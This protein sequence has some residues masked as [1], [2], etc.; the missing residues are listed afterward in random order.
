MLHTFTPAQQEEIVNYAAKQLREEFDNE[1]DVDDCLGIVIKTGDMGFV[2][3]QKEMVID[4][5][6]S[7]DWEIGETWAYIKSD[8]KDSNNADRYDSE[9]DFQVAYTA[10][11]PKD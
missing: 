6:T 8:K 2:E 4:F 7:F 3:L 9:R 1:K 5:C 10:D 11:Q